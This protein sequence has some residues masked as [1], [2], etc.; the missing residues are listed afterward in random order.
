MEESEKEKP[1]NTQRPI[2]RRWW[3]WVV[4]VAVVAAC[5]VGAGVHVHRQQVERERIAAVARK[6]AED[7]AYADAVLKRAYDECLQ[8]TQSDAALHDTI[9]LGDHDRTLIINAPNSAATTY[10][11]YNCVA[12]NTAMPESVMNK[13][14][15]T[16]AL[17]G[18][19]S[20]SW[21]N[22]EASWTYEG[23]SGSGLNV[24]L[25]IK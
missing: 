11:A 19:Q 25:S 24:T 9:I 16:T 14:S 20:D 6:R 13:I 22:I 17:S 2:W 3:A 23:G 1:A 7:K 21:A 12:T 5:A 15:N 8:Y 18:M 10:E 4:V